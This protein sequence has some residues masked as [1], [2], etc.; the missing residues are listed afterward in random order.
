MKL[1]EGYPYLYETHLHTNNSSACAR[2]TP[3]EMVL[4]C[5]EYGYTG[6]IVTEHNWGGN[7]SIDRSLPWPEF[8]HEWCGG[9]RRAKA[10]GD[11]IGF[12]VF[13]GMETGFNGTE[14]LV[15]GPD[16]EWYINHP[17]FKT[18]DVALQYKLIHEMNGM[19]IHAHPYREEWYID[20]IK[21]FD[22]SVIDG[23][24]IVNACHSNTNCHSHHNPEFDV[25]AKAYA[26][27]IG[28]ATTAGSDIHSTSLFG[29]GV[30][31][32]HK[33]KDIND[34]IESI[35]VKKDYILTNGQTWFDRE[36]NVINNC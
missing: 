14:F 3:E 30:A 13:L 32:S 10:K 27:K 22:S 9:Y 34:Y 19:V 16:E 17:E 18:E 36:G 5:K 20:E 21:T 15:Y 1:P 31:F 33:L 12:D 35:L 2:S 8:M 26:R 29:G 25:K 23:V 11:E 24:E 4:A 28:V 6:I 7:T